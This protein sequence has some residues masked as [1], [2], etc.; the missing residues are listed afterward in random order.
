MADAT[1]MD[2]SCGAD[3]LSGYT[4]SLS[5][6][7]VAYGYETNRNLKTGV[8]NNSSGSL[9]SRY[10]YVYDDI[11][12]RTQR[13]DSSF[14]SLPS[15]KTNLFDY[16]P[17]S[18]VV[19]ADMDGNAYG[20]DYDNIGNRLSF[21]REGTQGTQSV[22][23]AANGLNQYTSI[24]NG[25]AGSPSTLSYDD[26]GNLLS[27]GVSSY[28]WNG[29]NRLIAVEPVSPTNNSNR[30]EF[31]YDFMGRRISKDVYSYDSAQ[32]L[33]SKAESRLFIYDQWNLISE[34]CN[35]SSEMQSAKHFVWGLDLSQTL[36][37]AGGVGGLLAQITDNGSTV[38]CHYAVADANGNVTDYV[39]TNGT[40][41]AHFEYDP[42]GNEIQVSRFRIPSPSASAPNIRTSKPA[43]TTTATATIRRKRA[44]GSTAIPL[45]RGAG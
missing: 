15:V 6:I 17:R 18:E 25:G 5:A 36:Q 11:G 26:D 7:S 20:Y 10:D 1:H 3:L 37:G 9:V 41:A 22:A 39:S 33:W 42:Y 44:A 30:L 28:T 19:S 16:N 38:N 43:S 4:S 8:V 34:I 13:L 31:K 23:Y 12:R 45:M 32:S 27:D 2:V 14:A 24:T 29:E 40:L 35:D 21:N